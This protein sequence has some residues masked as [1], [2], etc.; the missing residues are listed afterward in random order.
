MP[1]AKPTMDDLILETRRLTKKFKGFVTVDH[2]HLPVR[3]SI[4]G[5]IECRLGRTLGS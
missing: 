2:V 4:L 1:S 5:E 3:R